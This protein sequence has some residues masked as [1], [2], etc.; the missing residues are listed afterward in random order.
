LDDRIVKKATSSMKIIRFLLMEDNRLLRDSIIAMLKNQRDI[1]F[2]EVSENNKITD[3]KILKLKPNIILL[4]LGIFNRNSFSTVELVQKKY[5]DSKLILIDFAAVSEDIKSF[6]KA[7]AA[8]FI[9]KDATIEDFIHII[10]TIAESCN[11]SSKELIGSVYSEIKSNN[12][13]TNK[14]KIDKSI[15]MTRR[16]CEVI[17][18]ISDGLTNKEIGSFMK[19]STFTVKS[20]IHN[21]MEKLTLHSR[22]ELANYNYSSKMKAVE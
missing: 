6:K 2:I 19:V 10:R 22:L 18:W 8:G 5:P 14:Y 11:I 7:G 13:H 17:E 3:V 1:K 15:Q 9:L 21:I 12:L 20:H 16:E 4:G